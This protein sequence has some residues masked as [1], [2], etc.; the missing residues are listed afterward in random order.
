LHTSFLKKLYNKTFLSP[1]EARTSCGGTNVSKD[2]SEVVDGN[3][4]NL[5]GLLFFCAN[6]DKNN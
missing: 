6:A 5:E 2:V 3:E 1:H 4:S